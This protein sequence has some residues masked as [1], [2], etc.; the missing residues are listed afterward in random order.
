MN[1]LLFQ[2]RLMQAGHT[3]NNLKKALHKFLK[4]RFILTAT[5]RFLLIAE[6]S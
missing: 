5:I 3:K 2:Q 4:F 6:N 1:S